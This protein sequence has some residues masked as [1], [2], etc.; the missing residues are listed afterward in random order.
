MVST[1]E[2]S[3]P[4]KGSDVYYREPLKCVRF[5]NLTQNGLEVLGVLMSISMLILPCT[6]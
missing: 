5:R 4:R 3:K 2:K 1:G 6:C